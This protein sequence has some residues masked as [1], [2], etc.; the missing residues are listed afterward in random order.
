MRVCFGNWIPGLLCFLALMAA[1]Q[2]LFAQG[3]PEIDVPYVTHQIEVDGNASDWDETR[4]LGKG[5]SFFKGDGRQGTSSANLGTT[6]CRQISDRQDCSVD[7]WLAHD[8]TYLYVLAEVEDDSYEPFDKENQKNMAY[9]ED[10]LHLYIDSNNSRQPNIPGNPI[11]RQPGYEQFGI[12]SDGN[13]WGE[14]TDFNSS[15]VLKQAASKGSTPDGKY[16]TAKC[17]VSRLEAGYLYVF[18]E[19][20]ALAGWPG[21]N[22]EPMIPGNSYGFDA[23]FCDADNGVQLQGFIW[24][25]SDGS[26]DAWNFENLWGKMNLAPAVVFPGVDT[27]GKL[28]ISWGLIKRQRESL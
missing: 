6:I 10:T 26:T 28:T 15:G 20:I 16:W 12:S 13:I 18:E 9:L 22:M 1:A 17:E 5:I 3:R 19:R 11:Q 2:A 14:N 24:W 25:S 21:R 7:L 4:S 27:A 23:E 8:G